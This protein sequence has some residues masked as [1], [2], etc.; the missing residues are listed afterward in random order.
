MDTTLPDFQI[1]NSLYSLS[2]PPEP[3]KANAEPALPPLDSLRAELCRR[4]LKAFIQT[5][6][7]I[8]EPSPLVWGWHLDATVEHLEAVTAGQVRRLLITIPPRHG[9]SLIV[10]VLWPCWEWATRPDGRWLFASY[11]ESLSIRDNVK[12]RRLIQSPWYQR[13]WGHVF[14]F[15][16]DQSE[17]RK[18]ETDRGG[19]R[20]AV[21]IGGAATGEGGDRLII[22]DAHNVRE[23]ESDSVRTGV[24]DWHDQVWSTRANDP[25]NT[26]RVIVGQRVHADDLAGHVLEQGGWEHL[27]LP[28]EYEGDNPVTS[29]G[30]SDPRKELGELL[31]PERFG[32]AEIDGAKRVL[33]SYAYSAQFQ[34]RPSPAGGGII[35]RHW[36]R[37][38]KP[39]GMNLAPVSVRLPDGSLQQ[40][41]A[42]D[43]PQ[44]FDDVLASWDMAFKDLAT[45]DYVAG[46]V[47]AAKMA[48]RFLLDQVR[49]RLSF[50]R[51]LEAVKSL[52]DKW[53]MTH[54]V[55]IEEAANGAAVLAALKHEVAGLIAVH[56]SGGKVARCQAVSPQIESG[57]VYLPHPAIA[58]WV[59]AFIEECA[60]FPSGKNDDQ[61]DEMTQALNRLAGGRTN[62]GFLQYL[63]NE[64]SK[65]DAE[66]QARMQA[67]RERLSGGTAII[68]GACPECGASCISRPSSGGKRCQ[69]CAWQWNDIAPTPAVTHGRGKW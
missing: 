16:S 60:Q 34:Q 51:T 50:P 13:N 64:L 58:P 22:D 35:K 69:N 15:A 54:R 4:S 49:E 10:S 40:I 68:T 47:W 31:W 8:V 20:I 18:M 23:A 55:L 32:A 52:R 6:W 44:E 53:P 2:L 38:W 33:G 26:A 62:Y 29:I 56:P 3:L 59:G 61:V 21:G 7:S 11:A 24:L 14:Q 63:E 39:A 36:F 41:H 42:I 57:N 27:S 66:T 30:W 5:S 1:P 9:K 19:H 28:A 25:K 37:Y 48:D 67:T 45:S 17:K 12:A 46:G 65:A 43:R